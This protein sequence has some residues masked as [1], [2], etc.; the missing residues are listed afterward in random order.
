MIPI[1]FTRMVK[2][3]RM[4]GVEQ[5]KH[6]TSRGLDCVGDLRAQMSP[7]EIHAVE[8]LRSCECNG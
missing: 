3:M 6:D 8:F 2:M 5:P 1:K 4:D 7:I